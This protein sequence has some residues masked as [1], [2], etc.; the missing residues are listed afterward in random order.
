LGLN[1]HRLDYA[2]A[3]PADRR[4]LLTVCDVTDAHTR[5]H[6]RDVL[7]RDNA[8]LLK[9]VRHRVANNLQI[10]ASVL[11]QNA[12]RVSSLEAS[13]HL[14]NAHYRVIASAVLELQLAVSSFD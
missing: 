14:H 8:L 11:M 5:E 2:G 13:G 9:E 7:A 4:L 10:I 6:L 3:G 12:R 1:A